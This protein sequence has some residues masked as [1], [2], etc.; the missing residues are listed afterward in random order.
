MRLVRGLVPLLFCQLALAQGV[1]SIYPS[2]VTVTAGSTQHFVI[3]NTTSGTGVTWSVN[4]TAGGSA[5]YGTITTAGLYTAPATVPAMNVV[6]VAATSAP[7]GIKG[8]SALT[9]SQPI[10]AV[11]STSPS[12]FVVG[13]NLSMSLNGAYFN[14]MSTVQVNG[15]AW[16]TTYV[17]STTLK[18]TGNLPATGTFPVTVT[19]PGNGS[20]TSPSVNIKVNEI[21]R[22]HV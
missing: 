7:S 15:V 19:N 12:T 9:I 18:A 1:V 3:Y 17:N 22:A 4:G 21:G 13:S 2:P 8:T 20:A 16:T 6:T 5:M 11:W 10:P 14:P